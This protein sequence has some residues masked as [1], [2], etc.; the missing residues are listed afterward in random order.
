MKRDEA[1]KRYTETMRMMRYSGKT[2]EAYGDWI[3]Q[4]ITF[5]CAGKAMD[6]REE[7]IGGFLTRLV[8]ERN[9]SATT[10]KQALCAIILFCR[11]VLK[12][13]PGKIIFTRSSRQK[14]LPVVLSRQEAGR[15]M[16]QLHGIGWLW[17]AYMYGCGLRLEEVCNLRVKDVDIDRRQVVVREGKGNKD[18]IVPL[19]D[20]MIEPMQKHLR[21]LGEDHK[22]YTEKRV[23]VILPDALDRKYPA[24]PFSWEWFWLFP[25]TAPIQNK[26]KDVRLHVVKPMLYHIHPSAVQKKIGR[27]IRDARIPKKAHCH[28]LRHSFATHWLE[29]AEG[30]HEIAL[31]RLQLLLG[32]TDIKTTQVYLHCLKPRTDVASPLDT[33]RRAA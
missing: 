8:V 26:S 5:L 13:T 23:P 29:N 7:Q 4:F 12:E 28:T 6:T 15:I 19:P 10:Q 11:L 1:M 30:S 25:V 20:M 22:R 16:D 21:A 9:V 32:H 17:G 24:A 2:I 27:A 18:R 31:L 3:S 14:R 33:L